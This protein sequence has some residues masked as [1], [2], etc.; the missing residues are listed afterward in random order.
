MERE[1]LLREI[2][3]RKLEEE[4]NTLWEQAMIWLTTR[5]WLMSDQTHND[6]SGHSKRYQQEENSNDNL[7]PRHMEYG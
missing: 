3:I 5:A 1:T 4:V 6:A 7:L 2:A